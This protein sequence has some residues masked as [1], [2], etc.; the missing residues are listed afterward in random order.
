[1]ADLARLSLNTITVRDQYDLPQAIEACARHGIGALAPWRDKLAAYGLGNAVR[2]IRDAG[3]RVS[4]LCRGGMLTAVD[5]TGRQAAIEDNRRAIDEA[6]ALDADSLIMVVG[7]LPPGSKDLAGARQMVR[8]G[9]AAVLPHARACGV[10]LAL[11]PLHPMTCADR[12]VLSTIAQTLALADEL[13]DG[14][15]VAID[16]YH[17]WWDPA[18]AQGIAAA[19]GRILGFHVSDWLLHT[20]DTV[21]DRGMMGDGVIDLPAIRAMVE[22]AGYNG[23]IEVEIMSSLDWWRCDPDELLRTVKQRFAAAV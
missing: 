14:T 10:P 18:L 1:M 16:C 2:H 9:L 20:R 23:L 19:E 4:S 21:L 11:E 12:A 6:A 22:A 13:G 7:G 5:A 17:T 15:G 8:D 3:L